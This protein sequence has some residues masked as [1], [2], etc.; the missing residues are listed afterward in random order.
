MKPKQ[1][2]NAQVW[3]NAMG[4]EPAR[5]L[6]GAKEP[7]DQ[8]RALITVT[9]KVQREINAPMRRATLTGRTETT[10]AMEIGYAR[11]TDGVQEYPDDLH[12]C[13]SIIHPRTILLSF[14][15]RYDN[16]EY[17]KIWKMK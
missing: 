7:R 14:L 10:T 9:M 6:D 3:I 5:L 2:T 16:L 11:G 8:P 4:S 17:S 15:E 1:E 12:H 13:Q